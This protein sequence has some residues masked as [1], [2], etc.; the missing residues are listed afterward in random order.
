MLETN[1]ELLLSEKALEVFHL[2]VPM[3]RD[4]ET[5]QGLLQHWAIL[6]AAREKSIEAA[7]IGLLK[8]SL[9][10]SQLQ[11]LPD[12]LQM[13]VRAMMMVNSQE[14]L[15]H[16][17]R[18]YPV[19][20][21]PRAVTEIEG[22]LDGLQQAD[23]EAIVHFV[24]NRYD[25]LKQ[26]IALKQMPLFNTLEVLLAVDTPHEL[27]EI[28]AQDSSFVDDSMMDRLVLIVKRFE[29]IGNL[30]FA[31][32]LHL[33][34]DE[35]RRLQKQ[36]REHTSSSDLLSTRS[37]EQV[38]MHAENGGTS[39][40]TMFGDIIQIEHYT[41]QARRWLPPPRQTLPK[42]FVGRQDELVTLRAYLAPEEDSRFRDK[43]QQPSLTLN[44]TK[45]TK[46]EYLFTLVN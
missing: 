42:T 44:I 4:R 38:D 35:V 16:H 26:I 18:Q 27:Q 20:L 28:I 19:L 1:T 25:I 5:R 13:A 10:L 45:R 23:Q 6:R 33:R 22:W 32:A 46:P 39:I 29:Q 11:S 37:D 15:F 3:S 43:A 24:N 17:I 9:L 41:Q 14:E 21:T 31:Q 7:Y 30:P 8:P 12:D 34:L 2:W 40:H 36:Q